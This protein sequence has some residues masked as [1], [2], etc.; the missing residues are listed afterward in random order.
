MSLSLHLPEREG[1][2][3]VPVFSS[4]VVYSFIRQVPT[5]TRMRPLFGFAYPSVMRHLAH[6][7]GAPGYNKG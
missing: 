6:R 1:R 4:D 3:P 5:P 7:I 2:K